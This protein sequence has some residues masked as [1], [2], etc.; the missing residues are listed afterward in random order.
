MPYNNSILCVYAEL[1][2]LIIA[3]K[4]YASI[5]Y[6]LM[7]FMER[8]VVKGT[9]LFLDITF[10]IMKGMW[11]NRIFEISSGL[12]HFFKW[13][14][15]ALFTVIR[16]K[17]IPNTLEPLDSIKWNHLR[18]HCVKNR[19]R[20]MLKRIKPSFRFFDALASCAYG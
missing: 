12:Y 16:K 2:V 18:S 10:M 5:R 11:N 14:D 7:I 1:F 3:F 9:S 8:V 13:K 17:I 19:K 20:R 6:L 4:Y 15:K